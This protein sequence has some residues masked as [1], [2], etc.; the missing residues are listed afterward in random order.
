MGSRV[1]SAARRGEVMAP[2]S[3]G[4]VFTCTVLCPTKLPSKCESKINIASDMR[5]LW[6]IYFPSTCQEKNY[7][8]M[9][10]NHMK[11]KSKEEEEDVGLKKD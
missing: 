1:L 9:Y 7:L 5:G 2:W 10:Y 3:Q 11:K 6:E 4:N 8:R